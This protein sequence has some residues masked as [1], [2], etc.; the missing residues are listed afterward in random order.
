MLLRV[1]SFNNQ[2]S[3]GMYRLYHQGDNNRRAGNNVNTN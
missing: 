1:A 3:G 2:R